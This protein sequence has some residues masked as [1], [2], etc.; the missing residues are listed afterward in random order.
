MGLGAFGSVLRSLWRDLRGLCGDLGGFCSGLRTSRGALGRSWVALGSLLAA[1]GA[2]CLVRSWQLTR[3]DPSAAAHEY[4]LSG[5]VINKRI[6][7]VHSYL[8]L[9]GCMNTPRNPDIARSLSG[10]SLPEN[11]K[12]QIER[13]SY[14]S[15]AISR[16]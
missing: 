8:G 13:M 7:I 15:F 4:D 9:G 14:L 3:S 16:K 5:R 2:L 1:L 12:P 10:K 6:E 11:A